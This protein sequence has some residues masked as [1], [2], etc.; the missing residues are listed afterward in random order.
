NCDAPV[1]AGDGKGLGGGGGAVVIVRDFD[2]GLSKSTENGVLTPGVEPVDPDRTGTMARLR[3]PGRGSVS[4]STLKVI[5][6]PSEETLP[7]ACRI[8]HSYAGAAS[9]GWSS[10]LFHLA[11][12]VGHACTC[13]V[14]CAPAIFKV[15]FAV[16]PIGTR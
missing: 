9:A 13:G 4:A 5:F 11:F 16:E 8:V 7:G 2:V 12:F 3:R 14:P 1:G 15:S 10:P 6:F